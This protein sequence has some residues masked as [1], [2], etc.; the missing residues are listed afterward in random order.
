MIVV[1]ALANA[2][3]NVNGKCDQCGLMLT[4]KMPIK[5]STCL[6]ETPHRFSSYCSII[7]VSTYMHVFASCP[8]LSV[9][10]LSI[11]KLDDSATLH[12]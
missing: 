2:W 9:N 1:Q 7:E 11:A 12:P 8:I 5:Q 4:S 6:K 3:Y 10:H